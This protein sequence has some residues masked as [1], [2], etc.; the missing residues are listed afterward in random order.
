MGGKF[1]S[2]M[3]LCLLGLEVM[4]TC[5]ENCLSVIKCTDLYIHTFVHIYACAIYSI[6]EHWM[7]DHRKA[8]LSHP[9]GSM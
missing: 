5:M 3:F 2:M 6:H 7:R 8:I 1:H 9:L 4:S